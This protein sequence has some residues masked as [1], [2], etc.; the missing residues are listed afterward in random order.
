MIRLF[1][2]CEGETEQTFINDILAPDLS[3]RGIYA[4]AHKQSP[5]FNSMLP[6]QVVTFLTISASRFS[7]SF[8][9]SLTQSLTL[10]IN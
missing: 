10:S 5:G 6:D 2:Y 8:R 1:V 3:D 9:F 4:T 7:G